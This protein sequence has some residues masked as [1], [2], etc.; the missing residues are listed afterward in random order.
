MAR[1]TVAQ[2]FKAYNEASRLYSSN[3]TDDAGKRAFE[4]LARI[5]YLL[6]VCDIEI[7]ISPEVENTLRFL[8]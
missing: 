7:E 8:S 3:P 6:S 5:I 1:A 2:V 4:A